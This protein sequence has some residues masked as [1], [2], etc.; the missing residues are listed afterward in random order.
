MG[1]E[2][3]RSDM[4]TLYEKSNFETVRNEWTRS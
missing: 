3:L 2:M 1:I 4:N